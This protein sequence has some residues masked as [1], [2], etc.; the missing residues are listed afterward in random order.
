M[1]NY[2]IPLHYSYV[3]VG[4]ALVDEPLS[5]LPSALRWGLVFPP[6]IRATLRRTD[7]L[8]ATLREDPTLLPKCHPMLQLRHRRVA[9]VLRLSHV[10]LRPELVDLLRS[11]A[12]Q[13]STSTLHSIVLLSTSVSRVTFVN[14]SRVDCRLSNLRE[15]Q[16]ELP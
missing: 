13:R 4:H 7:L 6:S 3:V 16:G 1:S 10:A 11:Y 5:H 14:R 2:T 12:T 15:A 8:L 9:V